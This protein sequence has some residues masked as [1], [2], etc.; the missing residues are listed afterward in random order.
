MGEAEA[1]H[2]QRSIGE[3]HDH[4]HRQAVQ[5]LHG[6]EGGV[7]VCGHR[8]KGGL[9]VDGAKHDEERQ[10]AAVR[11][12]RA[13]LPARPCGGGPHNCDGAIG[14]ERLPA[15]GITDSGRELLRVL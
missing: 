9:R 5:Q 11:Y 1:A 10:Q 14:Q 2:P 7:A 13:E 4:G 15:Q 8:G 6:E 3:R 12:E